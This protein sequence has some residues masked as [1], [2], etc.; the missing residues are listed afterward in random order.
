MQIEELNR[1]NKI[2]NCISSLPKKMLS[3]HGRDNIS[4]FVLH[5]LCHEHCFNLNK[6]A[7]FVNNPDFKCL[8]GIAGFS[9]NEVPVGILNDIWEQSDVFSNYMDSSSFNKRVRNFN[10]CSIENGIENTGI[11]NSE[12]IETVAQNLEI[13][14]PECYYLKTK[15]D[16]QGLLIYEKRE[17]GDMLTDKY[18][19]HGVSLLGFCPIF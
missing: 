17:S 16:N 7:Y 12:F 11:L 5:D 19:L 4:E 8:K 15:N 18:L 14:R 13:A 9:R 6:A 10:Q 1:Q 3:L 2:L